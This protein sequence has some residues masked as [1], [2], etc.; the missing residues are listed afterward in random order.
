MTRTN[1]LFFLFL[2]GAT[3]TIAQVDT[4]SIK[5]YL[6][7]VHERDQKTRATKDSVD[8][9]TF[10]D[11][12]NLL[13]VESLISTYGWPGISFVGKKGNQT[14]FLVI[15]HADLAIQVK[16]FPLMKKS[17]D[18]GE[19]NKADFALLQDRILMR[20]G[21]DQ[22]YGSQVVFDDKGQPEF[23]PIADE[24]NVNDRRTNMGLEPIEEYAERF[25][26]IYKPKQ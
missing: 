9:M 5:S 4:A 12:A 17:V 1:L 20:Q 24:K 26:I 22:I 21:K 8:F 10:F 7:I 6:N 13:Y 15:Q 16:Y 25:G 2:F 11:N 19:S 18:E 23:Y 14:V 3:S